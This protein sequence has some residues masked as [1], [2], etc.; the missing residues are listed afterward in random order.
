MVALLF[1]ALAMAQDVPDDGGA[2]SAPHGATEPPVEG[3]AAPVDA[4]ASPL[5]EPVTAPFD[6]V[7][8][9][10]E[11]LYLA[12]DPNAAAGLLDVLH[13][14]L[15][16]GETVDEQLA[17]E[18]LTYLG[19]IELGRGDYDGMAKVFRE[20]LEKDPDAPINPYR[21]PPEVVGYFEQVRG[22]IRREIA[23]RT[24]V[25]PP[26]GRHRAPLWTLAPLGIP[27]L[28]EGDTARGLAFAGAQG[29]LGVVSV[30]MGAHL[31]AINGTYGDPHQW[32]AAEYEAERRRIQTQ[33]YAVQWPATFA[34]YGLWAVSAV[35]GYQRFA[36]P[37]AFGGAVVGVADGGLVVSWRF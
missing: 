17:D 10:A 22:V 1:V 9:E 15:Q 27:Q 32:P 26:V 24:V 4:P 5:D 35:D 12:G 19:E 21:H 33:R 37:A 13:R 28:A 16:I 18:S 7:L 3:S 8:A 23:A 30:A 6:A 2:V 29:L 20:I 36:P 25:E 31:R 34:F 14:R 11:R